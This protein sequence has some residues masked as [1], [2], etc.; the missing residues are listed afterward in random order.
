MKQLTNLWG[1][2]SSMDI[3]LPDQVAAGDLKPKL[4]MINKQSIAMYDQE[5]IIMQ[6]TNAITNTAQ[7][8]EV[9]CPGGYYRIIS[10]SSIM[11]VF[12]G[13]FLADKTFS[14]VD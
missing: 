9:P 8:F 12:F 5:P 13:R 14:K 2:Y 7:L 10:T 11:P 6:K 3:L 1:I 4:M